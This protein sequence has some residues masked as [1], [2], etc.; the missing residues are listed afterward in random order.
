MSPSASGTGAAA[1]APTLIALSCT[2]EPGR[3]SVPDG[4]TCAVRDAGGIPLIAPLPQNEAEA[5]NILKECG[6]LLLT[7][8]VDA[9]PAL[10]GSHR[11]YAS[12]NICRVRDR[13]EYMLLGAACKLMTPVLGICR[14][15]QIINV[16]FGGTL[17]QDIPFQI[18]AL[19]GGG[20]PHR[21]TG[22]YPEEGHEVTFLE[23][24]WPVSSR[25]QRVNSYH[26]QA[27]RTPAPGFRVLARDNTDGLIEAIYSPGTAKRPLIMGVQWHPENIYR[28]QDDQLSIF[29]FF[30]DKAGADVV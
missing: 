6:G 17:Y 15:I 26:H 25:T 24:L 13:G 21:Q 12:E 19:P 29:R 8:G 18:R 1:P 9:D 16:Y 22:P 5:E 11:Q 20:N 23:E 3:Y 27:V 28:L 4:Y 30:I 14:G 10:Y 7:G 2:Y